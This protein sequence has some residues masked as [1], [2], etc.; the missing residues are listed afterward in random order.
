VRPLSPRR[1]VLYAPTLQGESA[2]NNYTSLDVLGEAI[3]AAA[4]AVPDVRLVYKPHPRVALGATPN[5]AA[6]HDRVVSL[7]TDADRREPAAGHLVAGGD[8]LAVCPGCDLLITDVS[9]SDQTS[10]TCAPTD[11][12]FS[13]TGTATGSACSRRRG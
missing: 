9:S 5:V 1:T 10:S 4:L 13:P 11:R 12:S 2:S 7:V 3:I 6:A 8:I